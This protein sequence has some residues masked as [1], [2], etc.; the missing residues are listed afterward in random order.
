MRAA[1]GL[2]LSG[3]SQECFRWGWGA[4]AGVG[5][6]P[7]RAARARPGGGGAPGGKA[8]GAHRTGLKERARGR[9]RAGPSGS[10]RGGLRPA[11]P[12][13]TRPCAVPGLPG[14]ER[15]SRKGGPRGARAEGM[16]GRGGGGA[17]APLSAALVGVGRVQGALLHLGAL[18]PARVVGRRRGRPNGWPGAPG[19]SRPCV[20]ERAP[21]PKVA[22]PR[23]RPGAPGVQA[24]LGLVARAAWCGLVW[25]WESVGKSGTW[26]PAGCGQTWPTFWPTFHQPTCSSFSLLLFPPSSSFPR[27]LVFYLVLCV[28]S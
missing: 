3:M 13:G 25:P 15:K 21:S 4:Q 27:R 26:S 20:G 17:A 16:A 5:P 19:P 6:A 11:R 12:G 7:T 28:F 10:G 1:A 14:G 23:Q 18:R 9:G 22:G 2:P 8:L 24:G